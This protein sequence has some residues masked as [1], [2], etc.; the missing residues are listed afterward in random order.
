MSVS[1]ADKK[2]VHSEL[3][4]FA[5]AGELT[6][7]GVLG[8]A[9]GKPARWSLWKQVLDE[10]AREELRQGKPDITSI[11]L[12]AAT[13]WPSQVDFKSTGD[14]PDKGQMERAQ[15]KL[16]EVFRHYYPSKPTPTLPQRK[17]A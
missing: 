15:T 14:E 17:R 11:V 4:K 6:Y 8:A 13:G 10:I 16:D 9:V 3:M 5:H 2:R 12:S 7:Y 1:A